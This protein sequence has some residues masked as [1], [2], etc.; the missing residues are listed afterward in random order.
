MKEMMTDQNAKQNQMKEEM[1]E[2]LEAKIESN[3]VKTDQKLEEM[4]E[5]ILSIRSEFEKTI[6]ETKDDLENQIESFKNN[7]RSIR[8]RIFLSEHSMEEMM[9]T[10][11]REFQAQLEEVRAVAE[12]G[13]RPTGACASAA[14]PPKF[15]GT[16][17]WEVF[18]RQFETVAEHNCWMHREKLTYLITALKGRA[19]DVLH[20]IPTS[21]TYE[22]TLQALEDRF[23]EQH[24]AAAYRSQL[25]TRIQRAGE[26]LQEFA[27]AIEQLVHR[28]YPTLP[29]DHIKREAGKAFTDGV[30]D[31]DIKM[32]LLLG[33]EKTVKE[34]LRQALELQAV[35]QAARPH[36]T[37]TQTFW[38][39]R[40]P[41]TRRRD[42]GQSGCWS[43]GEPGHFGSNCPYGKKAEYD[44][45]RKH[46]DRP[47]QNAREF[48]RFE[49]R[50]RDNRE[51]NRKGGKLSGNE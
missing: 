45:R 32:Q 13:S 8:E 2:R 31:P 12:R 6:A 7:T 27:M 47:S 49:K 35:L 26:S 18:Q 11:K 43:C 25:K 38:G 20:T 51:T 39:S 9:E 23:G 19:A 21:A 1:L 33:G 22:E 40:S 41:P 16:T 17:S 42:A 44:R 30:E 29:E 50:P 46:E 5:E 3:Q 34:A 4:S 10:N 15:D 14:Q 37:R 48:R 36:R 24:F 28:A